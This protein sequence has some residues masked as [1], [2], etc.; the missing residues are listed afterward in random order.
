MRYK[1]KSKELIFIVVGIFLLAGLLYSFFKQ[2]SNGIAKIFGPYEMTEVYKSERAFGNDYFDIYQLK[3]KD[4]TT[5][6]DEK[7]IGKDYYEKVR[8]FKQIMDTESSNIENYNRLLESINSVE[9]A[10]GTKYFYEQSQREDHRIIYIYNSVK[11][12]GYLFDLQI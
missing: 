1:R 6:L 9:K 12:L 10:D 7:S 2:N 11:D 8:G 4:T 5:T 3:L